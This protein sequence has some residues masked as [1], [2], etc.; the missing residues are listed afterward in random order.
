M[1]IIYVLLFTQA[2]INTNTL[3]N[4][5]RDLC[6][7]EGENGKTPLHLSCEKGDLEIVKV[8]YIFTY[9]CN[10]HTHLLLV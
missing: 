2:V 10:E 3:A 7:V 1:L 6:R 4:T 8:S 9:V 5:V